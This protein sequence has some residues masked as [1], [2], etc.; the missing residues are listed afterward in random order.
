[1]ASHRPD[2]DVVRRETEQEKARSLEKSL[3]RIP[4]GGGM[5]NLSFFRLVVL[6][7]GVAAPLLAGSDI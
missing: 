7:L 1:M 2:D 3:S 4:H 5:L 6:S